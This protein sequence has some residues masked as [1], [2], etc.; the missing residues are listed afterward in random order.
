[1]QRKIKYLLLIGRSGP[2]ST[3]SQSVS[4][5]FPVLRRHEMAKL[6]YLRP[7]HK[8]LPGAATSATRRG[9]KPYPAL[10]QGATQRGHKRYPARPH[11]LP[12]A[13]TS[14]TRRGPKRYPARPQALPGAATRRYPARPQ[15]AT[16]R[17]HQRYPAQP[18]APHGVDLSE[19]SSIP[20]QLVRAP[21][22]RQRSLALL[23]VPG[24][25]LR[26]SKTS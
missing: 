12:G 5:P 8:S 16:Q 23:L 9:H 1:M 14:A 10:P 18:Q 26:Y 13:A 20:C 4:Q 6:A 17:D 24:G 21:P 7:G 11:A 25:R 19:T 22:C 3:L 15:G 2:S